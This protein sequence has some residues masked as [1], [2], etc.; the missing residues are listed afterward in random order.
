MS[1]NDIALTPAD[2]AAGLRA[3]ADVLEAEGLPSSVKYPQSALKTI[4][5]VSSAAAVR[6]FALEH[7]LPVDASG[8]HTTAE[9]VLGPNPNTHYHGSVVLRVL[10]I[11]Y[12]D[13]AEAA[14]V[15]EPEPKS[16][17]VDEYRCPVPGCD[18]HVLAVGTLEPDEPDYYTEGIE[19]HERGHAVESPMPHDDD[20]D[21]ADLIGALTGEPGTVEPEPG[22]SL[23]PAANKAI[24]DALGRAARSMLNGDQIRDSGIKDAPDAVPALVQ[25]DRTDAAQRLADIVSE[26]LSSIGA[27]GA[28]D[29]VV[30][31]RSAL[32]DFRE[33]VSR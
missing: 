13:E 15:E 24:A 25:L 21:H 23:P 22:L 11:D 30:E 1:T 18:Y 26:H 8:G 19:E 14:S 9:L 5:S 27:A 3:L 31:L 6:D 28:H 33:A 7:G 10:H 12:A 17:N 4:M 16:S 2:Y 29:A 20:L 32:A